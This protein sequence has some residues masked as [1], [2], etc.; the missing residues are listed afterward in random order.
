MIRASANIRGVLG[1]IIAMAAAEAA[2][3]QPYSPHVRIDQFGYLPQARKIAVFREPVQGFDAPSPY[4]PGP[5]IQV[6][7]VSDQQVVYSAAPATWN[8]GAIH[9]QS[10]DRVWRF[11]F[12]ALTVPGTYDIYDPATGAASEPFNIVDDVYDLA[13]R[14]AVRMYYYQRCGT[15]KAVPHTSADWS[16]ATC[17]LGTQQDLDC[18]SV[19]NP[20]P[21][22]SRNLSGGWHDAGDYNKYVNYADS[23]LH[24]LLFAYQ[25]VPWYWTD[26]YGIPESGNGIPDLL[27]EI[28]WE[29]D[30]L[31][32][33]QNPDGSVLHKM[34][35]TDFSAA[36]PPSSDSGARRYAP[37][38]A[39]ATISA[40]GAYAHAAQVYASLPQTQAYATIL[41][42][43]AVSAWNWL[44]A[45]PGAIPSSYNNA[46]F[47][48]AAAEESAYDQQT[49]RLC[50]AVYLFRLTGQATYRNY[51]DAN[52]TTAHLFV[53]SYASVWEQEY[54]DALLLYAA[55][56]GATA[57]VAA[58]I[59]QRYTASVVGNDHLVQ[60]QNVVDPYGAYLEDGNYTWGSNRTKSLQ[61][62][63]Y[64]SMNRHC[65]GGASATALRDAAEALAHY[66]HGVNPM[67]FTYLTNMGDFGAQSSVN[68]MYHAWFADGTVWDSA[69]T[70]PFGPPPGYLTGGP[71]PS[72]TPDASYVG[73]PIEP[74]E[75]QPI[76]KSYRDWNTNWP[77]NSWE[78]TECH[79]P[80]QA[81]YVR[82]LANV[83]AG[84]AICPGDVNRDGGFDGRDIDG[85][86]DC[87]IGGG[88]NCPCAD[89]DGNG[90]TTNSDVPPFVAQLL[91]PPACL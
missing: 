87:I 71:N 34:A 60:V 3:A 63:M 32:K 41:Q 72:Y 48:N 19:S 28:K 23:A 16:D 9:T 62:Q 31:L 57:S 54:N 33:M 64:A 8:G 76:Q 74:P 25:D 21:A 38:T 82:L 39:S 91:N 42:T 24:S 4:S 26:D 35:V 50:A 83:A 58:Q 69:A 47:V 1:L 80:Y 44:V 88:T 40:C 90:S 81:A 15:P 45:N 66:F 89:L 13:L 27:D 29:L 70:S 46:G 11:D 36:S 84:G 53:W 56:P 79:I 37:A 59:R 43:A 17:H 18:R 52:Y 22:T 10:G 67:G 68:E 65:L 78:V 75:N 77:Q 85:F 7:R 20:V 12:S 14:Q 61:G 30:W 5:L 6:R 73:P 51:V 86:I 49:S 2:L 55:S